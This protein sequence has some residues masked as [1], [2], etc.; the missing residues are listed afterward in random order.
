MGHKHM[1]S[2]MMKLLVNLS[3]H[4]ESLLTFSVDA[5]PMNALKCLVPERIYR[6]LS[7]RM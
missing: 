5:W 7:I 4:S 1:F 3:S 6:N 2:V